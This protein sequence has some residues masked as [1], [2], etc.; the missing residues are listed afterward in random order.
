MFTSWLCGRKAEKNKPV[1][2]LQQAIEGHLPQPYS[3]HCL[4]LGT[5][6]RRLQADWFSED[7]ASALSQAPPLQ[8]RACALPSGRHLP[9]PR[10]SATAAAQEELGGGRWLARLV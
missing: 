1:A 10:I 2:T 4:D 7:E 3:P 8:P 6:S 9:R 5:Q